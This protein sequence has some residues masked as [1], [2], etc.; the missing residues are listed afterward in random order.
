[1]KQSKL[2]IILLV[3][4]MLGGWATALLATDSSETDERQAHIDLAEE[5]M[6]RGLFQKAIEEYD[7][8]ILLAG[9]EDLWTSKLNAYAMRYE[10]STKIYSDYVTAAKTAVSTYG[11]NVDFLITLTEL[12]LT[13]DE[14]TSAYSALKKATEAGMQDDR[15]TNLMLRVKYAYDVQWK[16]Y[17][18]YRG[19]TNGYYAVSETGIWTYIE[20]DGTATDYEK[21]TFAGPVGASGIRVI[22]NE[23]R[24]ELVDEN[25]IVQGILSFSPVQAGVFAE[26][27]I[28][29]H[30]GATYNY[31]NS[32]GDKQFGG[33]DAA[34]TFVNGQ[35]A[36]KQGDTWFLIDTN[37]EKVANSDFDEIVLCADQ[38][39]IRNGVMIA[40]KDGKYSFYK[41]ESTVGAY[42]DT[43]IIT[44]DGIVAVCVNGK[45]GFVDLDGNT[46]IA[47]SYENA[48]SFSNGLA[49]V[50]NG[51][52]WGFIDTKG[53]L[54][55][56][57]IFF[58]AD[59]FNAEGCCMVESVEGGW[60]I[61]SLYIK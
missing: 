37:G 36:V 34:G 13:R 40:Q 52:H 19:N 17:M 8:A 21:L 53:V 39:H 41:E 42:S 4:L 49:A 43:D 25:E 11:S 47:P 31:Y 59:Y 35:A 32:L 50:Y 5:Y 55:I 29:I 60:Q 45:W 26:G 27:L 14:Y 38:S 56:D 22:E 12:Y 16:T 18:E 7:A 30:D 46:V 3:V 6:D 15:I 54:V 20:E 23:K 48:K 33:F 1:M 57:Y 51:E 28:A 44:D 24:A 10:E 9:S 61:I 58:D 2:T